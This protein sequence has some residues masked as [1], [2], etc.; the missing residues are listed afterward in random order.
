[1]PP[2]YT[3]GDGCCSAGFR[4]CLNFFVAPR[5]LAS[6]A[7]RTAE[8]EKL[9]ALRLA[10][11]AQKE[12]EKVKERLETLTDERNLFARERDEAL[13]RAGALEQEVE[14]IARETEARKRKAEKQ[15]AELS[16]RLLDAMKSRNAALRRAQKLA[17]PWWT[18]A[19]PCG[20]TLAACKLCCCLFPDDLS[21]A[22]VSQL[23]RQMT[24]RISSDSER[25]EAGAVD[26]GPAAGVAAEGL[27]SRE[28]QRGIEL[29]NVL[30]ATEWKFISQ[31][32]QR[33]MKESVEPLLQG[34]METRI[35][36]IKVNISENC[37]LGTEP[38]ML[39]GIE[40]ETYTEFLADAMEDIEN[41]QIM[42]KLDYH[43]NSTVDLNFG[44]GEVEI[45]KVCVTGLKVKGTIVIEL[46]RLTHEPPWFSGVRVYFPTV[47]QVDL[48]VHSRIVGISMFNFDFVK[49]MIIQALS[50]NVIARSAVLPNRFCIRLGERVEDFSLKHARPQGVLRLVVHKVQGLRNPSLASW[51]WKLSRAAESV[52]PYVELAV[53]ATKSRTAG[54]E[55]T[56]NP[57]WG[58]TEVHDLVVTDLNKQSLCIEVRDNDYGLFSR[59]SSDF[60]GRRDI[61]V[62][63]LAQSQPTEQHLWLPLHPRVDTLMPQSHGWIS[64]QAQ[65]R[66]LAQVSQITQAIARSDNWWGLGVR[67]ES[68][69]LLIVE[70]FY[71]SGLPPIEDG[72]EH[73]TTVRVV[74]GRRQG[75]PDTTESP[76]VNAYSSMR[77]GQTLLDGIP[78]G[79]LSDSERESLSQRMW[80]NRVKIGRAAAEQEKKGHALL[81]AVW[82][83]PFW[84]LLDTLIGV[85]VQV[86]VWRPAKGRTRPTVGG[87]GG[88]GV[89][90]G[91]TE[92]PLTMEGLGERLIADLHS[93]LVSGDAAG[94]VGTAQ[95]KLRLKVCPLLPPPA[96]IRGRT[97]SDIIWSQFGQAAAELCMNDTAAS[98]DRRADLFGNQRTFGQDE[99]G[100][101]DA[102]A[103]GGGEASRQ[104][105]TDAQKGWWQRFVAWFRGP[106]TVATEI[107][108]PTDANAVAA[109]APTPPPADSL[110]STASA[111]STMY[112]GSDVSVDHRG[113]MSHAITCSSAQRFESPRAAAQE[114]S[115]AVR[116]EAKDAEPSQEDRPA[117][118]APPAKSAGWWRL[119]PASWVRQTPATA[120]NS[121]PALAAG[122]AQD[123]E[124]HPSMV[125]SLS[126]HPAASPTPASKQQQ[127]MSRRT[128]SAPA[129][130]GL[131]LPLEA[132]SP[133][134]ETPNRVQPVVP[135]GSPTNKA[136]AASLAA[137]PNSPSSSSNT[138]ASG[139]GALATF[140]ETEPLVGAQML[141]VFCGEEL[142][143][144]PQSTAPIETTINAAS[145]GASSSRWT[146]PWPLSRGGAKREATPQQ[147]DV[148][149]N[150]GGD[151]DPAD[152]SGPAGDDAAGGGGSPSAQSAPGRV[153]PWFWGGAKQEV[154]SPPLQPACAAN[155]ADSAPGGGACSSTQEPVQ[156]A[157]ARH[158]FWSAAKREG[159][160]SPATGGA[161]EPSEGD[162]A[163]QGGTGSCHRR[164]VGTPPVQE[165]EKASEADAVPSGAGGSCAR[166]KAATPHLQEAEA[167]PEVAAVQSGAIGSCPRRKPATPPTTPLE[168]EAEVAMSPRGEV[169]LASTGSCPRRKPATPP[170]QEAEA[171]L[172]PRAEKGSALEAN[173]VPCSTTGACPRRKA[174]APPLPEAEAA[175]SPTQG[176]GSASKADFAPCNT[177]G[178]SHSASTSWFWKREA[179]AP[180]VLEKELS[181]LPPPES[182]SPPDVA[183]AQQSVEGTSH[184][185]PTS[186]FWKRE[187][188]SPRLPES[189]PAPPPPRDASSPLDSEVAQHVV[190]GSNSAPTSWFWKREP[191]STPRQDK[192][193]AASLPRD[194]LSPSDADAAQHSVEGEAPQQAAPHEVFDALAAVNAELT[195][196]GFLPSVAPGGTIAGEGA[197]TS[198]PA[199]A[200]GSDTAAASVSAAAPTS[201]ATAA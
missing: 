83:H 174:P 106:G 171:V 82:D 47:P 141:P 126:E 128:S 196:I 76:I 45:G 158:W 185:A 123:H 156:P 81:D 193:L 73:W 151:S 35:P 118:P 58:D 86:T 160:P 99:A 177:A 137:K 13:T 114:N 187:Q 27:L 56:L 22:E 65:W 130:S 104:A 90:V 199:P 176:V 150:P 140:P 155:D 53:G 72:T 96:P 101:L 122:A 139:N 43:G 112:R 26:E 33:Q 175:T 57:E 108:P 110:R 117:S 120:A 29:I 181:M 46:V 195:P 163:P 25:G 11:E 19:L 190:E 92:Y 39:E 37:S 95:V 20:T 71:A 197:A 119:A 182:A 97:T 103:S 64:I 8:A 165:A 75:T 159:P 54:R 63:Q 2:T 148:A 34:L 16:E 149:V 61:P 30:I 133:R 10:E 14:N 74:G 153:Y 125:H 147:P 12:L 88:D 77:H 173:S 18:R 178:N 161:A 6:S 170:V 127:G 94:A 166:R 59:K 67:S 7:A 192:K 87:P 138:L 152:V 124:E 129:F 15:Q 168:Q 84:F 188:A 52:E 21:S 70:L 136:R 31:W 167:A 154:P 50:E 24:P 78:P 60:L 107:Q 191:P 93:P 132:K 109:T 162:A 79:T 66:P 180:P 51:P 91:T 32:F 23:K 186:W 169:E 55:R 44:G 135:R 9:D 111:A 189:E 134:E 49:Q 194:T 80:R 5:R 172:S 142:P 1:M 4:G 145:T 198:K 62:S 48:T 157:V 38:V 200:L 113:S 40:T 116:G 121:S 42:G 36:G 131:A 28:P 3:R 17:R 100:E 89:V 179:A 164:N 201:P 115:V 183:A 143:T 98:S 146:L 85:R 68:A 184:S 102:D 144:D 105:D 69:F 41:M